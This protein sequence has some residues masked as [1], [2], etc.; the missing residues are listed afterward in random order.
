M[1]I[2]V[3]TPTYNRRYCLKDLFKSLLNQTNQR[4]EWIVV[5]DGSNDGTN[6]EIKQYIKSEHEFDIRYI[7]QENGGKHRAINH[8]I[9]EVKGDYCFIV[10]S[11]D[12][13]TDDAIESV[14]QWI[15]EIHGCPEYAGVAGKKGGRNGEKLGNFP[16][17]QVIDATNIERIKKNLTGDKAEIYSTAILK[18][19]PFPEFEGEKFLGEAA[20]WDLIAYKG[21]KIRWHNKVIYRCSYLNDGLT[22]NADKH[23]LDSFCGYTYVQRNKMNFYPFPYNVLSMVVYLY[24]A[25][26]KKMNRVE[27]MQALKISY[28]KYYCGRI[29]LILWKIRRKIRGQNSQKSL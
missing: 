5:D 9:N 22:Q 20:V 19:F 3:I 17:A 29:L 26:M 7:F 14:Y 4:F 15:D 21:Y 18:K 2:S 16:N 12:V 24:Y 13:L 25:E 1:L 6:E 27:I 23:I 28:C 8:A 10:D 11:D